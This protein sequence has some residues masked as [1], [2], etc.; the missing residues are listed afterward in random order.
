M[1]ETA[2]PILELG[3]VFLAAAVL[4]FVARRVGLPA[5][6]GYLMVGLVGFQLLPEASRPDEEFV[7]LVV[8]IANTLGIRTVA[9]GVED[10]HELV[11]V[12]SAGIDLIQGFLLARP[13]PREQLQQ[14]GFLS[15]RAPV[16]RCP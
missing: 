13:M 15:G 8:S 10:S 16:Y 1:E 3:V 14:T 4:G 6:V 2:I 5:V 11:A 12:Q 7:R 9:E